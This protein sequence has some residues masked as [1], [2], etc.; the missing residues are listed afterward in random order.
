MENTVSAFDEAL[1]RLKRRLGVKQD[2]E[3]ADFLGMTKYAFSAR[4]TRGGAFPEDLLRAAVARHPDVDF[5]VDW[6]LT[7]S[8]PVVDRSAAVER[9]KRGRGVYAPP[10]DTAYLLTIL[11]RVQDLAMERGVQL[12]AAAL[13][14]IAGGVYNILPPGSPINDALIHAMLQ[15]KAPPH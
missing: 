10:L 14:D 2:Q 9:V 11:N 12:D 4:K 3:V 13:G 15:L 5:D 7:G 1:V 6:V 8:I